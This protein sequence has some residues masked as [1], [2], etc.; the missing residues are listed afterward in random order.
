[1]NSRAVLFAV[2]LLS[3]YSH[4][5]CYSPYLFG[6]LSNIISLRKEACVR[7]PK[8][9]VVLISMGM[10][11]LLSYLS[12]CNHTGILPHSSLRHYQ[13]LFASTNIENATVSSRKVKPLEVTET[14]AT[15][16]TKS[17]LVVMTAVFGGSLAPT[18][19]MFLRSIQG[20]GVDGII[21]GGD[22]VD[23]TDIIPPNVRRIPMT[24]DG[25]H[26][27]ISNRLFDGTPLLRFQA[28][29]GFKVIDVKPLFGF[30]FRE[31]IQDYEFWA[32]VDND[33][34]FGDIAGLMNPLMDEFDVITPLGSTRRTWGP[35]TAYCNVPEITELFRLID[36]DLYAILNNERALGIDEW[37]QFPPRN[38]SMSMSYVISKHQNL[39][40]SPGFTIGWDWD[41][42]KRDHP[43]LDCVW[44][45]R[46]KRATL[47]IKGY[48]DVPVAL[49][50]FQFSKRT[51]AALLLQ[52]NREAILQA[53]SIMWSAKD[54]LLP[55]D[56]LTSSSTATSHMVISA[57]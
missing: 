37:C 14:D 15:V 39:R 34:V 18:F 30:L 20:G 6:E 38:H 41:G 45:M 40:V 28:A 54:G 31:Y 26:E 7:I 44:T 57:G 19:P 53:N 2:Y 47:V 11:C 29:R 42:T 1:M 35:Y 17:R 4:F 24:W 23:L 49:C 51:A 8:Q 3:H 32:H 56:D 46:D 16:P 27:L 48:E 43:S 50:H 33:L 13:E 55:L 25:L 52:T 36:G 21:I 9:W 12:F 10:S 22:E 5:S